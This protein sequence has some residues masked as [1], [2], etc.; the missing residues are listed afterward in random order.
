MRR[1][2]RSTLSI[3]AAVTA[4]LALGAATASAAK[5]AVAHGVLAYTGVGTETN[6]LRLARHGS[7]LIVRDLAAS[8][9]PGAGCTRVT[10]HKATCAGAGVARFSALLGR[11]NDRAVVANLVA[12]P[13]IAIRGGAGADT[14]ASVVAHARFYGG[15]GRDRLLGGPRADILQGRRGADFIRGRG[16]ADS[17]TGGR[18]DDLIVSG[19]GDDRS[20]GGAGDD[21]VYGSRGDDILRGGPGDDILADFSG[22]D[23]LYGETGEDYLNTFELVPDGRP[24]D[25]QN[26]STG[27]DY[28][29]RA[30]PDDVLVGCDEN[31]K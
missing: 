31:A 24:G 21:R 4:A 30:S 7:E 20:S 28:G 6:D 13:L 8:L 11:G 22:W 9:M 5:V 3:V 16:G 29:C 17:I 25:F 27:P 1:I 26:A 2:R 23:H 10:E 15:A 14:L 18:G 19:P 12:L